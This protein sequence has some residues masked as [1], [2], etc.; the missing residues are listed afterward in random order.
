[1]QI[2]F[3]DHLRAQPF[4]AIYPST[5]IDD[6]RLHPLGFFRQVQVRNSNFP[7]ACPLSQAILAPT[8]QARHF[9]TLALQLRMVTA[10]L[11]RVNDRA[12]VVGQNLPFV[13]RSG[14]FQLEVSKT[15]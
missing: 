15:P 2:G 8:G 9:V 10:S 11:S 1:M 4:S 13:R 5:V 12:T 14:A 7:K 6:P 3:H